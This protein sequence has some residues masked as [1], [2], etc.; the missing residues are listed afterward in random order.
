MIW[1]EI[2]QGMYTGGR[3][4]DGHLRI[5]PV[6]CFVTQSCLTLLDP[7]DCSQP[8]SSVQ[9]ILQ[10]GTLEWVAIS[11]SKEILKIFLFLFSAMPCGL[12]DLSSL[13]R[14]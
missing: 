12:W 6:L 8:G 3:T 13:T 7:M 2:I 9:G 5:Q 4:L 14:V 11:Y 10:T 1:E